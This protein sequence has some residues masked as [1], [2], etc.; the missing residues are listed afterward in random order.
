MSS[1]HAFLHQPTSVIIR[2]RLPLNPAMCN[3]PAT[4][5]GGST[6][7]TG[8]DYSH[9]RIKRFCYRMPDDTALHRSLPPLFSRLQADS[10]SCHPPCNRS[11]RYLRDSRFREDRETLFHGEMTAGKRLMQP[12]TWS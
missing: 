1:G 9:A 12:G 11:W 2:T 8:K 3:T 5:D 7:E 6:G 4:A 10:C